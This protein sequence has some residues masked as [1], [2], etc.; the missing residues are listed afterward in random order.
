MALVVNKKI[1]RYISKRVLIVESY[2]HASG[3]HHDMGVK[4]SEEI[5]QE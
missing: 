1:H 5:Y 3:C 2:L 4:E